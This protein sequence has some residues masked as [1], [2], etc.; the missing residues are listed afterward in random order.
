MW[1]TPKCLASLRVL[2]W[3]DPSGGALRVALRILACRAGVQVWHR[4]A[5]M[6]RV[7]T[8][9]TI[10]QKSPLAPKH[11]MLITAQSLHDRPTGVAFGQHQDQPS[12]T[13]IFG[14]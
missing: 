6:T 12:T 5:A 9:N 14:S 7:Q 13:D 3:V 2:Q 11:V 8:G 4:P 1:L 10:S